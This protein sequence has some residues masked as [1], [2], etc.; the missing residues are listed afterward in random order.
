MTISQ[1]PL[2]KPLPEEPL[3]LA[4]FSQLVSLESFMNAAIRLTHDANS[5][6]WRDINT[7]APLQRNVGELLMLI[8]SE[9]AEGMEGHRKSRMDDHLPQHDSLSVELADAVIRIF[10]LAGGLGLP[11]AAAWRDKME[12]NARRQDHTHAARRAEGGKA[13]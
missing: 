8:V 12:Y 7:G 9:V 6:W 10:D 1:V 5:R 2:N 13:Y 3:V 11:L 4:D